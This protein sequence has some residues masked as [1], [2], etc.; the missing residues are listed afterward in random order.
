MRAIEMLEALDRCGIKANTWGMV[1][2]GKDYPFMSMFHDEPMGE[3]VPGRYVYVDAAHI[4]EDAFEYL[5][6]AADHTL[7]GP[8]PEEQ[9]TM[10][11][12]IEDKI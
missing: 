11:F 9:C 8:D 4:S 2:M 7:F 12:R 5:T 3:F 10:L 1:P 6:N